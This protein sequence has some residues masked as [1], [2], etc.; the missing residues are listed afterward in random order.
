[1]AQYKV[2]Q[3]IEAEDKLLG[4]L[5]LRQFI[6]AIIVIVIGFV[7]FRLAVI[8]WYL[9]IPF[10]PP[11]IFFAMLAA[12]FG[13]DQSSEV[14]M[15]AKIKFYIFPRKRIWNQDGIEEM[16]RVTAPKIEKKQ[17]TKDFGKEEA[18]SRLKALANTMDTR[19]WAIKNVSASVYANPLQNESSDRLLDIQ[20]VPQTDIT[21][22]KPGEDLLDAATTPLAQTI[23]T[24]VAENQQAHRTAVLQEMQT[25]A[26]QQKVATADQPPS[27]QAEPIVYT[28]TPSMGPLADIQ[29]PATQLAQPQVTPAPTYIPPVQTVTPTSPAQIQTNQ[30]MTQA[31]TPDIIN[32]VKQDNKT[33]LNI[34]SSSDNVD[35]HDGEVTISLH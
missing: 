18:R 2:L 24:M 16:V 17:L 20:A 22:V 30:P 8:A 12:P 31:P 14:W 26:E 28:A 9:A 33:E 19:G 6:Y 29:P 27:P 21:S 7:A 32:P 4:P 11:L 25:I 5:T 3:D 10:L 1:M 34:R 15:L 23:N 35:E 13:H